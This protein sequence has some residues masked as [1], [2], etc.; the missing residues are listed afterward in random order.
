[1]NKQQLVYVYNQKQA[2]YYQ[3]EFG[4]RPLKVDIHKKT[5]KVFWVFDKKESYKAYDAW[6]N[7]KH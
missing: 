3:E 7:R 2:L 6:C 5:K 1:M 4:V